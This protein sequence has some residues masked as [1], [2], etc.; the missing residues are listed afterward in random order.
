MTS[1]NLLVIGEALSGKTHYVEKLLEADKI[2]KGYELV[3]VFHD[4]MSI[5]RRE[6]YRD[7]QFRGVHLLSPATLTGSETLIGGNKGMMR[8]RRFASRCRIRRFASRH[9]RV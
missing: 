6:S 5:E 7:I 9:D 1:C 3:W 8:S 4:T 2:Y